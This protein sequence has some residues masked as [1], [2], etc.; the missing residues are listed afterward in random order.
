MKK[1]KTGPVPTKGTKASAS[2]NDHSRAVNKGNSKPVPRKWPEGKPAP[3]SKKHGF[4][5]YRSEHI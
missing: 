5:N 1:A 4:V 2:A 3:I